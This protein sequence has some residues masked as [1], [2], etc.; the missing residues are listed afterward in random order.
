M[1]KVLIFFDGHIFFIPAAVLRS[2]S[3]QFTLRLSKGR[4]LH[5]TVI[6]FDILQTILRIYY[7][8]KPICIPF[9]IISIITRENINKRTAIGKNIIFYQAQKKIVLKVLF[10][11]NLIHFSF[12][13]FNPLK[14]GQGSSP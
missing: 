10:Q 1:S 9:F 14:S 4:T 11:D 7:Y 5:R 6:L 2:S 13:Y 3:V 12:Q 8:I